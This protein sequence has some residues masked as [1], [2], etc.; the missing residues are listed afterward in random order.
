MN[1]D[2]YIMAGLPWFDFDDAKLQDVAVSA[3]LAG[4]KTVGALLEG[5]LEHAGT[6]ALPPGDGRVVRYGD[7]RGERVGAGDW[8]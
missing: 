2:A 6:V 8:G 5:G 7:R 3:T 4:V 1:A